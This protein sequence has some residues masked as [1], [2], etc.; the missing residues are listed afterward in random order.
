MNSN[1]RSKISGRG[2]DWGNAELRIVPSSIFQIIDEDEEK[3]V[4]VLERLW[5]V[6][7]PTV[8]GRGC[9]ELFA[10]REFLG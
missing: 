9:S 8:I 2:I 7:G 5:Q 6:M 1:F 4:G 10:P 3:R